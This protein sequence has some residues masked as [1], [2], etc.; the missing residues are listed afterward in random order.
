MFDQFF[1]ALLDF[2]AHQFP[3]K[4]K[5]TYLNFI[6]DQTFFMQ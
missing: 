4:F 6:A 1:Y 3:G 5:K 2:C